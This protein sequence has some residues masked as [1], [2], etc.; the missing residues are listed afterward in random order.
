MPR[1]TRKQP[2]EPITYQLPSSLPQKQVAQPDRIFWMTMT[3]KCDRCFAEWTFHLE[4]GCEGPR[5]HVL[6]AQTTSGHPMGPGHAT[7]MAYT[8]H[9]REVVPVPMSAGPCPRCKKGRVIHVRWNE[10]AILTPPRR[11]VGEPDFDHFLYPTAKEKKKHGLQ[12][13]GRPVFQTS[14]GRT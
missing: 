13:C 12:A 14:Q 6:D 3:Y 5:V 11:V 4:Q 10:D 8:G 1:A 9:M 2:P 7:Q